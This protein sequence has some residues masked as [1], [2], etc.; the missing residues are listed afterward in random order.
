MTCKSGRQMNIF[1]KRRPGT[2]PL[3][4]PRFSG[5]GLLDQLREAFLGPEKLLDTI[6]LE[7]TSYCGKHCGY[8]AHTTLAERWHSRHMSPEVMASLWPGLKYAANAHLQG[9]GEPLLHP[10][11]FDFARFAAKAGCQTSTTTCGT[12]MSEAA[13]DQI[14]DCGLCAIAFSL[15][16][17][18]A[19]S[20]GAR[21]TR[22]FEEVCGNIR[23]LSAK[24]AQKGHGPDI[25]L[26]YLLLADRM[27]AVEKLP[28]LMA[29][30]NVSCAVVSTL[31]YLAKP[32]DK[33]LAFAPNEHDKIARAREKLTAISE[34]AKADGKIIAF[35]LP[36][37]AA[38]CAG[39]CRENI[40]RSMYIDG[41]GMV[42]PCVY[43][44]VPAKKTDERRVVFGNCLEE[45][46]WQIW[47]KPEYRDFRKSLA[48]GE[49]HPSCVNCPKRKESV[50]I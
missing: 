22:D 4:N 16:G 13:L 35:G 15:V 48:A 8:C 39:G 21:S 31:D 34:R 3:D 32:E 36:D 27:D 6:Q 33:K 11:F 38:A 5:P 46:I 20:N 43:L 12:N 1:K 41:E 7:V 26:A 42:S 9:W 14:I 45:D 30:L 28:E 17:T 49:P 19:E 23:A 24:I 18:D 2:D 37:S 47:N 44:N 25:H 10:R 50:N 40:T 29:R